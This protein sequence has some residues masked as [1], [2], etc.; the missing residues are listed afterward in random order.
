MKMVIHKLPLTNRVRG[1]Y[2]SYGPSFSPVDLWPRREA[3]RLYIEGEKT[4]I[5]NLQ[6]GPRKQG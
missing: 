5:R 6:Y 2:V 3:H 4:R 1:L